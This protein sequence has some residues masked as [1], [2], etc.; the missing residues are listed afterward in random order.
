MDMLKPI[1]ELAGI[2]F[3][4]FGS[5]VKGT[6]QKFSDLDLCYKDPIDKKVLRD[7]KFALED[8]NLPIFVDIVDYNS[9]SESFKNLIDEDLV[10]LNLL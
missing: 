7:I 2:K 3:Y 5:R 10:E 9:C 1:L 6:N 8:S 4:A